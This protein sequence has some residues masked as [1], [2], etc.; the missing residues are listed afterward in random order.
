MHALQQTLPSAENDL[1]TLDFETYFDSDVSLTKLNI[2]QYVAHPKFKVWG[3]GIKVNGE[4]PDWYGEGDEAMNAIHAIDW[5][6]AILVCHNTLFDGYILSEV[7]NVHPKTYCDTAAMA[8]G[9]EPHKS[10]SLSAVATRTFP[11]DESMRKGVELASAKGI[12]DLS[13]YRGLEEDI[14]GYCI[15]DVELTYAIFNEMAHQFPVNELDV[16]DLTTKLFCQPTLLLDAPRVEEMLEEIKESTAKTIEQS[17][18][19]RETLSSSAKFSEHLKSIGIMPPTKRSPN[20][21]LQIPAFGKNDPGWKQLV[22]MYPEHNNLWDGRLA[23]KSRLE[24][25]RADRFLQSMNKEGKLPI[26]LRYYAAHTGRFGGTEK[27]N[28]QNLP[29]ESALRRCLIA[30]ENKYVFVADLSQIEARMLAWI[31]NEDQLLAAFANNEDVYCKFA[32]TIYGRTITKADEEERFVGKTAVLGLGYGMGIDKFAATLASSGIKVAPELPTQVVRTYRNTYAMIPAYWTV[33][34]SLLFAMMDK[35][36]WGNSFGP[37]T[38]QRHALLLPNGMSLTY[39]NLEYN[40]RNSE[41]TFEGQRDRIERT[42]GGKLVENIVQALSRIVITDSML[43]LEKTL[44][45][46]NGSV[47]HTVHDEILVVAPDQNPQAM[48]DLLIAD[49]C[50]PP[51]WAK[52]LPLAAEGKYGV[53]YAK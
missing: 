6:T 39:P 28:M 18:I 45:P 42:Y 36:Q 53:A 48:L 5:D 46:L 22:A 1:I 20:T 49:M 27:I 16:I 8:R 24:E 13:A 40:Y 47:V 26:P 10:A 34:K 50:V 51:A 17:G 7:Y 37:L 29:R 41:F 2:Q 9:L 43:R 35:T 4:Q 52:D 33:A 14:A 31:A 32:T 44:K 12:Y 21:G 11:D 19:T 25:T 30:P 3:V 38:V 15:Q 23:A